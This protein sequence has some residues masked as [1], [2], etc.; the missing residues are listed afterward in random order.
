MSK[1]VTI[2]DDLAA[3]VEARQRAAGHPTI[4]AAADVLIAH[5]LVVDAEGDYSAGR[6]DRNLRALIDEGENSGPAERWDTASVRAEVLLRYA[7]RATK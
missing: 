1:T 7:A 6:T 2:S 4:D 5:D 3:L